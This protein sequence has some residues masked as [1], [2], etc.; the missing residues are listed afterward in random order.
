[1][2]A[3]RHMDHGLL[4]LVDRKKHVIVTGGENAQLAAP[5]TLETA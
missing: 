5:H 3:D 2:R 1:M 4:H